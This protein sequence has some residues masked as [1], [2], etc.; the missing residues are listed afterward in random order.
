MRNLSAGALAQIA[1]R[2]GNEP[3]NIIEVAW[4]LGGVAVPYADRDVTAF[5]GKIL[6]LTT[7]DNVVNVSGN[8]QSHPMP[9]H[10]GS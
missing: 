3:I 5:P 2:F 4:N 1:E 7:L 6:E 8:S 9:R 10:V